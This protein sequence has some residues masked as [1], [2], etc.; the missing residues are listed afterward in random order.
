[1]QDNLSLFGDEPEKPAEAEAGPTPIADWIVQR[2]REGLD[3]RG[4]ASM[5]E[6]QRMI[7]SAAGRPV[8]SL[9][10]LTYQEGLRV[11]AVL[12][13]GEPDRRSSG[14]AWDD[15]EEDTWIDRL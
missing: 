15:R 2:L 1:M 3:A 6:R 8:E 12:D 14:T 7:E 9:R 10:S 4:L 5:T 13:Q 11:L